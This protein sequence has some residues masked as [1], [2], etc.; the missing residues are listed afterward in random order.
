MHKGGR[1]ENASAEMTGDEEDRM[2]NRQARK[3][4][5]YDGKGTC[6]YV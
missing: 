1:D 2:R 5:R 4:L 3:S 6:L